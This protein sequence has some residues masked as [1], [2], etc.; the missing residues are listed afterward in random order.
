MD[1]LVTY[2][3]KHDIDYEIIKHDKQINSAHEGAN[4]FGIDIGQTAPT[5]ILKTEQGFYA[6][7]IS[8][9]YGRVNLD[10]LGELLKVQ[11]VKLAKPNEIEKVTGYKVGSIP[12]VSHELPTIIDRQLRRYTYV[13][14]GTGISQTTLKI[15]PYDLEKLNN[16]VGYIR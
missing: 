10:D 7:V 1:R 11:Q 3:N 6:L 16:I 9:D 8:G 4:Y 12:L 15:K 5:I 13:Y 14:G 2:L